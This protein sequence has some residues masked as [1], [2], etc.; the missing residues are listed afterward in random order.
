MQDDSFSRMQYRWPVAILPALLLSIASIPAYAVESSTNQGV[1]IGQVVQHDGAV[2]LSDAVVQVLLERQNETTLS[3]GTR[4]DDEGRFR[5][6]N[7]PTGREVD[8]FFATYSVL[9]EIEEMSAIQQVCLSPAAYIGVVALALRRTGSIQGIIEDER[10]QPVAGARVQSGRAGYHLDCERQNFECLNPEAYRWAY[11]D[12]AGRFRLNTPGIG[13]WDLLISAPAH[14]FLRTNFIATGSEDLRVVLSQ[15]GTVSGKVVQEENQQPV[16]N[17]AVLI[18]SYVNPANRR[19]VRT[20]DEGMF[21]AVGLADGPY[22]LRVSDPAWAATERSLSFYVGNALPTDGILRTVSP[23]GTISGIVREA[24]TGA[25]L[26]DTLV[27]FQSY[28]FSENVQAVSDSNGRYQFSGLR[29]GHYGVFLGYKWGEIRRNTQQYPV[30]LAKGQHFEQANLSVWREMTVGG[31]VRTETGE[32]VAD[33]VVHLDIGPQAFGREQALTK[34]DGSFT[35]AGCRPGDELEWTVRYPDY[36]HSPIPEVPVGEGT[37]PPV[38]IVMR[39]GHT[40]QGVL[41][42]Q[43]GQPSMGY[44]LNLYGGEPR[45]SSTVPV[46]GQGRFCFRGVPKGDYSIRIKNRSARRMWHPKKDH[47]FSVQDPPSVHELVLLNESEGDQVAI[48]RVTDERGRSLANVRI[49]PHEGDYPMAW[50]DAEGNFVFRG[51][52]G[53]HPVNLSL[54]PYITPRRSA[55]EAENRNMHFVMR[56]P[57]ITSGYVVDA[58]TGAPIT[59]FM[60]GAKDALVRAVKQNDEQ[61][62]NIFNRGGHF[63]VS[64]LPRGYYTLFVRA[65]GYAA[66]YL[67][68]VN[69]PIRQDIRIALSKAASLEVHVEDSQGNP[70][71]EVSVATTHGPTMNKFNITNRIDRKEAGA[72][73]FTGLGVETNHV[74]AF[75]HNGRI[76]SKSVR[77]VPGEHQSIRLVLDDG[78]EIEGMVHIQGVPIV[79]APLTISFP[80]MRYFIDRNLQTDEEGHYHTDN[81]P[82]GRAHVTLKGSQTEGRWSET[83]TTEVHGGQIS[84]VNFEQWKLFGTIEGNLLEGDSVL[85]EGWV[86]LKNLDLDNMKYF[87]TR[88]DGD[89]KYQITNIPEGQYVLRA[90]DWKKGEPLES[91][92]RSVYV[93]IEAGKTQHL[94]IDL[95]SGSSIQGR[96]VGSDTSSYFLVYALAG[97]PHLRGNYEELNQ[98]A[99]GLCVEDTGADQQGKFE[100]SGLEPGVYT[101]LALFRTPMDELD[102]TNDVRTFSEVIRVEEDQHYELDIQF[103]K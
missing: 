56:V 89:G 36:Y 22:W 92:G 63:H 32:P 2:P 13:Y 23:A 65:P 60:V 6:V 52:T 98:T 21:E 71:P 39:R 100:L 49:I 84:T 16:P 77:I 88:G 30:D 9:V 10:G 58:K 79:H 7:L 24:T 17:L 102:T 12:E 31:N 33:A 103:P 81:L 20:N 19:T 70:V 69:E 53:I 94:D 97:T 78:G 26:P 35:F 37:P 8:N 11:S 96:T 25:P 82:E 44:H 15:G 64:D 40:V 75:Q 90:E 43:F 62:K 47:R 38:E 46:D 73:H 29:R 45:Y 5:V 86:E 48:G 101:I 57:G 18:Q 99:M 74:T 1:I 61:W 14:A 27:Y 50:S 93:D 95:D 67:Q 76:T 3:W 72:F 68:V 28:G 41:H 59:E 66:S 54:P 42:D 55:L 87:Q 91:K 83:K 34:A 80:G 85:K 51:L 4:S